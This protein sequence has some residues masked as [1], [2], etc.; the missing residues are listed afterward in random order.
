MT[1]ETVAA[2]SAVPQSNLGLTL[3]VYLAREGFNPSGKAEESAI[4]GDEPY[5]CLLLRLLPVSMASGLGNPVRDA[6]IST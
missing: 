5:F 6:I 3:R 1:D 4:L 2:R